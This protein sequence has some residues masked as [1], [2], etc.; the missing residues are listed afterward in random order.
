M[1]PLFVDSCVMWKGALSSIQAQLCDLG[2]LTAHLPACFLVCKMG[3]IS[4]LTGL[5]EN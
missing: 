1:E 5:W 3:S 2:H 4:D